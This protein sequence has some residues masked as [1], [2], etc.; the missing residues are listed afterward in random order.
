MEGEWP[1]LSTPPS[2]TSPLRVKFHY[3]LQE[4]YIQ[5]I[6]RW[7]AE[8]SQDEILMIVFSDEETQT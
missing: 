4:T 1:L 3:E 5:F 2:D 8:S 6:H 7:T